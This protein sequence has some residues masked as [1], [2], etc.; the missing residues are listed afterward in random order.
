MEFDL[1]TEAGRSLWMR[2]SIF[3]GGFAL[4]DAVSVRADETL[5]TDDMMD[6]VEALVDK[7]F[8]QRETRGDFV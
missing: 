1:C 6:I 2:G 5:P 3:V 4:E 7:S 8:L